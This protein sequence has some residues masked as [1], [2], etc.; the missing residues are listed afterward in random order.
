MVM[1]AMLMSKGQIVIQNL[2]LVKEKKAR[3][4]I[5]SWKSKRREM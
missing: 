3:L 5:G 4:S 2:L 1:S